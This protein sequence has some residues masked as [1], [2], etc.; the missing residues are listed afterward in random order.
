MLLG[1]TVNLTIEQSDKYKVYLVI[2]AGL[3]PILIAYIPAYKA[4]YSNDKYIKYYK[5]FEKE[6][7]QWHKK[8]YRITSAFCI[9][10]VL[11]MVLGFWAGVGIVLLF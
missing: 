2:I 3:T 10:G 11:S 5:Q 8:W 1:I 7:E 9:G 4:V 6:S